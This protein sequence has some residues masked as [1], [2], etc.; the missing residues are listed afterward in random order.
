MYLQRAYQIVPRLE[1][2][3]N[4][5]DTVLDI[6]CGTG[7]IS[8][9]LKKRRGC[10]ITLVD[11]A[12]NAMCDEFPVIIYDGKKLPFKENEFS[13]VLLIAC[14]HH[15]KNPMQILDEAARVAK[16]IIIMEDVFTDWFSRSITFISDCLVNFEIHSPFT[17][18]TTEGWL[19]IF[20]KKNLKVENMEEF[21][22]R[23]A[24]L[25][26]RLAIFILSK[27]SD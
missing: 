16:K 21:N 1:R 22:L 17:N 3:I 15:C 11:V 6:G 5:N 26:F 12:Y 2:F 24:G 9:T 20:K 13:E 7:F 4:K 25:P 10:K 8:K 23:C 14:L 18:H 19:K 27:V